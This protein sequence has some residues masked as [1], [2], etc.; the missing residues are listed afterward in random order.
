MGYAHVIPQFFGPPAPPAKPHPLARCFRTTHTQYLALQKPN[1]PPPPIATTTLAAYLSRFFFTPI[2]VPPKSHR[3]SFLPHE[4][5][6][7]A[8]FCSPFPFPKL[9]GQPLSQTRAREGGGGGGGV[10]RPRP[11]T[12]RFKTPRPYAQI[13]KSKETSKTRGK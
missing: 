11:T 3:C 9:P 10:F 1:D 2:L 13:K 4:M 12:A 6:L 8:P 7:A 5:A